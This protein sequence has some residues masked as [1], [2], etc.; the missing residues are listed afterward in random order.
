LIKPIHKHKVVSSLDGTLFASAS[1][2]GS[3]RFRGVMEEREFHPPSRGAEAPRRETK[4]L[5]RKWKNDLSK[6]TSCLFWVIIPA[7]F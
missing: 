1:C 4:G 6:E 5:S 2:D 3:I 7:C